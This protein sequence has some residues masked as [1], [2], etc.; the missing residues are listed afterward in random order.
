MRITTA[1]AESEVDGEMPWLVSAYDEFTFDSW[2]GVPD[3]FTDAVKKAGPDT[4]GRGPRVRVLEIE[5]PQEAVEALFESPVTRG[6][7]VED[8]RLPGDPKFCV[9]CQS[10]EHQPSVHRGQ[11]HG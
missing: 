3:F 8:D 11:P 10:G 5:I 4:E 2:N 9:L 7:V 6:E 1:W